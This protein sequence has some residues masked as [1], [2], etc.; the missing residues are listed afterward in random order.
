[1]TSKMLKDRASQIRRFCCVLGFVGFSS[2]ATADTAIL[3]W[4]PSPS[5]NVAGYKVYYGLSS[6]NYTDAIDV[7]GELTA[8]IGGLVVGKTYYFVVTAYNGS[9]VESARSNEVQFT[10]L[11][12]FLRS[13]LTV[14]SDGKL[15]VRVSAPMGVAVVLQMSTNLLNWKSIATNAVTSSDGFVTLNDSSPVK[16]PVHLYRAYL[17]DGSS[18]PSLL[19]AIT[20]LK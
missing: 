11:F 1:M 4:D 6:G 16:S 17:I 7:A 13:A 18:A 3:A 9:G 12:R 5:G 8:Q 15:Q 20:L 10:P 2:A 14:Q 19:D